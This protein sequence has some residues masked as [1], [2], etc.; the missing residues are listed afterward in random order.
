MPLTHRN[1]ESLIALL[2]A[3]SQRQDQLR[4]IANNLHSGTVWRSVD[5]SPAIP[6]SPDERKQLE[7]IFEKYLAESETIHAAA[8][9][10]L[11]AAP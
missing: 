4:Q 9:G 2:A 1:L 5:G 8:R 7:D 10:L 3:L 6:L 11:A